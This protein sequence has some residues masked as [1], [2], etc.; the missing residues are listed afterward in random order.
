MKYKLYERLYKK[1]PKP[2]K[3][4]VERYLEYA[5]F[6]AQP[7]VY[8]G[9]SFTYGLALSLVVIFLC[10]VGILPVKFMTVIPIAVFVGFQFFTH[11]ML[12]VI[13]ESRRNFVEEVL[14]DSLRLLSS[15]IRSGLTMDR[16]LLISARP[17]FGPLGDA[18]KKASKE[19]IAGKP[20]EEALKNLSTKVNSKLLRRTMDLLI[21]G[22]RRGGNLPDL[23]DSLAE[24]IRQTKVLKK[25]I[26]AVVMMYVIFIF[27]AVAIGSPLLY[28][29]ST[30]L[31]QT[32]SSIGSKIEVPAATTVNVPFITFKVS[33]V[34]LEFLNLY[35]LVAITITSFFGGLMLGLVQ[36]GTEKAGL[37]YIPLLIVI[38]LIVYFTTRS[39]V[40]SVF[41]GL[42]TV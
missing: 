18:M 15:N 39:L 16:A 27:F 20:I 21:E 24:D 28:S 19:I 17:E 26:N 23:L 40:S 13:S 38:S 25:E 34:D 30:F 11:G 9:F 41:R 31:I 33:K 37:K 10:Y 5:G 36:E 35:S 4:W 12:I 14:P 2:Y 8:S 22:L 42:M 3:K 32:I 6:S 7:Y 1:L 29:I